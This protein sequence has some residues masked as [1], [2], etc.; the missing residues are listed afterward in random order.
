MTPPE[1]IAIVVCT[2]RLIDPL[3][4]C[5]SG[6][7][8]L[9]ERPED[10][11]FI[12]NGSS[13]SLHHWGPERFPEITNIR[14]SENR[15][16]CGGY[17]AGIR[18]GIERGYDFVLIV[19]ADTEVANPG[20]LTELLKTAQRWPRAAFIGPLVYFRSQG[21]IQKTCLQFPK[22]LRNATIWLPW[23][24][25]QSYFQQQPAEETPVEFL[26]GICVL[27]RVSAL[28][29]F[30]LMDEMF[31]GYVED[32]DWA[33]RALEKGWSSVFTPVPSVIH[34]ENSSGYEPYSLKTFLLK[35]NTVLWFLKTEKRASA[36]TYAKLSIGLEWVR[37]M[38]ERSESEKKKHRYFLI[39]LQ[40]AYEGL[41]RGENLGEWFG[42]P[43][44]NWNNYQDDLTPKRKGPKG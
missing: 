11:I 20:F 22:V 16:F 5:L 10:I 24:L 17:N 42:P 14:L 12:D 3:E 7:Q 28:R 25:A 30:G 1:R 2:N 27:C 6:L 23:R 40:R 38:L 31:C 32:A 34:H 33:W 43:L 44:S 35:R 4:R 26:N 13:D 19:N 18:V 36:L 29:E 9:V 15:F 39:R 41:L 8:S 21:V 37:M